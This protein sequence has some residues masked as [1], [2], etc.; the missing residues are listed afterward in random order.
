MV[1]L[2]RLL[3]LVEYL[4]LQMA[5]MGTLLALMVCGDA[6][7][8]RA[9]EQQSQGSVQWQTM[10]VQMATIGTLLALIV[11][12]TDGAREGRGS[13]LSTGVK[14]CSC[15]RDDGHLADLDGLR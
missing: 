3:S 5:M 8:S 14:N 1:W 13:S 9:A 4:S 7:K 15:R 2:R 10:Q 6:N 12:G 11:Y